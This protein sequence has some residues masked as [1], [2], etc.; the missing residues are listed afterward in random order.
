MYDAW[1]QACYMGGVMNS[2]WC[3]SGSSQ[4]SAAG[5]AAASQRLWPI[6]WFVRRLPDYPQCFAVS[7]VLG[8]P[9]GRR[10]GQVFTLVSGAPTRLPRQSHCQLLWRSASLLEVM[11]GG[12]H[13]AVVTS[14]LKGFLTDAK[15]KKNKPKEEKHVLLLWVQEVDKET[16]DS[17]PSTNWM[18]HYGLQFKD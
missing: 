7:C 16:K 8:G 6:N 2:A 17:L 3:A 12:V 10:R 11:D 5:R 14:W 13:G 15:T 4:P 9:V 1:I 18:W